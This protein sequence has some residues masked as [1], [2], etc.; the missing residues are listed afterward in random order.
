MKSYYSFPAVF[1]Y[2]PDGITITFPDLPGCMSCADNDDEASAMALDALEGWL[3]IMDDEHKS[4][5]EPTSLLAVKD[6]LKDNQAATLVRVNMALIRSQNENKAVN[7]M[8][9]LPKWLIEE[10]KNAGINFSH[11]LHD[12]LCDKLGYSDRKRKN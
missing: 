2:A 11:T 5:P 8:V 12:A 1:D 10:G 3:A 4:L 9:T 7:K 6:T